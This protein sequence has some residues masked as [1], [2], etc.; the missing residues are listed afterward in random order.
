MPRRC[1]P[2]SPGAGRAGQNLRVLLLG[3]CE[4]A[5]IPIC[6]WE[7]WEYVY[8]YIY[9]FDLSRNTIFWGTHFS[10]WLEQMCDVPPGF[11]G[12]LWFSFLGPERLWVPASLLRH[13]PKSYGTVCCRRNIFQPA[14]RGLAFV[15]GAEIHPTVLIERRINTTTQ[16]MLHRAKQTAKFARVTCCISVVVRGFR[17]ELLCW[18]S[19]GRPGFR[20]TWWRPCVGARSTRQEASGRLR[21]TV[22]KMPFTVPCGSSF[23][24]E[25]SVHRPQLN[26]QPSARSQTGKRQGR[27]QRHSHSVC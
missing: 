21:P 6:F 13:V 22:R 12:D 27:A 9:I 25:V 14:K 4:S 5:R 15:G 8:I 7:Y 19:S 20:G 24:E 17:C 3:V 2:T 11:L 1:E 23:M 16:S 10:F 18:H 26:S